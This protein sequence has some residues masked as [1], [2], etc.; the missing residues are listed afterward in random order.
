MK[1]QYINDDWYIYDKIIYHNCDA[2]LTKINDRLQC[3]TCCLEAPPDV[4]FIAISASM[5]VPQFSSTTLGDLL[6]Q[7]YTK[8]YLKSLSNYKND[9]WDRLV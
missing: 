9:I 8:E 5:W 4:F 3:S 2:P 6:K 1:K 7:V